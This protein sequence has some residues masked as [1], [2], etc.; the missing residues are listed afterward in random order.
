VPPAPPPPI[1]EVLDEVLEEVI[2]L[3]VVAS[4]A[5]V[6]LPVAAVEPLEAVRS[7]PLPELSLC[8]TLGPHAAHAMRRAARAGPCVRARWPMGPRIHAAP[9]GET[10]GR[11]RPL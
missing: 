4:L 3:V 9:G 8:S 2:E 5:P 7:P 11:R 10:E 6:P 1:D